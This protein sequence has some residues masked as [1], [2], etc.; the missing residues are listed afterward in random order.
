[1][2]EQRKKK[3]QYFEQI[4]RV[5]DFKKEAECFGMS[6]L[7]IEREKLGYVSIVAGFADASL[8]KKR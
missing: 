5:E 1:M 7:Q 2:Q 6:V 8:V 3:G 4:V